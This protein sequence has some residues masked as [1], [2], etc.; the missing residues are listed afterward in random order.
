M[1]VTNEWETKCRKSVVGYTGCRDHSDTRSQ[2]D[3]CAAADAAVRP[4]VISAGKKRLYKENTSAV[5]WKHRRIS[6]KTC[7]NVTSRDW[8]WKPLAYDAE[9]LQFQPNC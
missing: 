4:A 6:G 7:P 2:F 1:A 5:A 9:A 3:C 8:K